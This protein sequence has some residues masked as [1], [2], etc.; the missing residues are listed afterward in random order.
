MPC[1]RSYGESAT[2]TRSPRITRMRNLRM[3]P[4][5]WARTCA[6]GVRG[7]FEL[8]T[9]EHL[10]DGALE[11][12]VV[13]ALLFF[14][15]AEGAALAAPRATTSTTAAVPSR[16]NPTPWVL[17]PRPTT[18]LGSTDVGQL[19]T[20]STSME[21]PRGGVQRCSGRFGPRRVTPR[22]Q[23]ARRHAR[24]PRAGTCT[25]ARGHTPGASTRAQ[26]HARRRLLSAGPAAAAS[27]P[28]HVP[29]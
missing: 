11:L 21:A 29:S 12:D 7:H 25:T 27:R 23:L 8:S 17:C 18:P 20:P 26:R 5:S 6:P 22:V 2:V 1:V 13:V 9:R 19:R 3:R 14:R 4:Q 10:T 24:T 15:L 16:Q 28:R